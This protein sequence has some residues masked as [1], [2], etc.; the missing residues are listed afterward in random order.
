LLPRPW[1]TCRCRRRARP[2]G[3]A[4]VRAWSRGAGY[5]SIARTNDYHIGALVEVNENARDSTTSLTSHRSI[6]F[7]KFNLPWLL[8][9]TGTCV[10][11]IDDPRREP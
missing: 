8:A 7:R 5:S 2:G 11:P 10:R 4:P 9:G 6:V 1:P 3:P